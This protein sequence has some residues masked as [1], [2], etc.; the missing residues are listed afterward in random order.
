MTRG[1]LITGLTGQ[2]GSYLAELLLDKGYTV[3][4]IVRRSSSHNTDRIDPILRDVHEK[5]VKLFRFYGDLSDSNS[6]IRAIGKIKAEGMLM[7]HEIYNLGAQS[8]VGI[9]FDNPIYTSE[10]S[11][12]G[13]LRL[14][15]IIKELCPEAKFYQASSSEMFGN[16]KETPQDEET[17]FNPVSPYACAKVFAHNIT[18]MYRDAYGLHASNG[19]LFN[20]ESERRGINFVTRKITR[21]LARIKNGLE[22]RLFLGNLDSKRDWGH[23]KDYVKAMWLMLQQDKADDYV[24]GTGEN[25][26]VRDFL[27][28]A[29]RYLGMSITS[30]CEKDVNEKYFDE[31]GKMIIGIDP[32]FVRP[33][34]VNI[35]LA[36]PKKAK[37][38]LGWE[39]QIKFKELVRIMCDYDLDIAEK[40]AFL[41]N[42]KPSH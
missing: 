3:Y 22:E 15:E 29:A 35:L 34:D 38:K 36:N 16:V 39:P 17:P 42:R 30:N 40:E 9:S 8:H 11:G 21:G 25:C 37:E 24:I 23:S 6:I 41:K 1:A 20:H 31:H 13:P 33:L 28:E 14:L 5:G 12:I 7:P 4:G 10:I 27:E 19:I 26:S 32:I 2:D 18:K